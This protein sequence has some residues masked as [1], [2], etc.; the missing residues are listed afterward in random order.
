MLKPKI[1]FMSG[2]GKPKVAASTYLLSRAL[3]ELYEILDLLDF[4]HYCRDKKIT[5]K[6]ARDPVTIGQHRLELILPETLRS[7]RF[8]KV[9][10]RL[11]QGLLAS[12]IER[13]KNEMSSR[14]LRQQL[15]R[16][17]RAKTERD[18]ANDYL[19]LF[20]EMFKNLIHLDPEGKIRTTPAN[21]YGAVYR[22]TAQ[23]TMLQMIA[24]QEILSDTTYQLPRK[25]D[26]IDKAYILGVF[27]DECQPAAPAKECLIYQG[28]NLCGYFAD[29]RDHL[30]LKS[31]FHKDVRDKGFSAKDCSH[32]LLLKIAENKEQDEW[33]VMLLLP[34]ILNFHDH[35][36]TLALITSQ[37]QAV[38]DQHLENHALKLEIEQAKESFETLL[39]TPLNTFSSADGHL[40]LA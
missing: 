2:T 38:N 26:T 8:I 20:R 28:Q 21:I 12:H 10:E 27:N 23:K 40:Q 6:V 32:Y 13:T 34:E 5:L 37:L 29:R 3:L 16:C 22:R 24:G 39:H 19:E 4:L 35:L 30:Y 18:L 17:N 7:A 14:L 31:G 36:P 33:F 9:L 25:I 15:N 1:I 11:L